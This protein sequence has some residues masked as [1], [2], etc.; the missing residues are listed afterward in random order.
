MLEILVN[1]DDPRHPEHEAMMTLEC[2]TGLEIAL[3]PGFEVVILVPYSPMA[4]V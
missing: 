3:L 2:D 1:G 4:S